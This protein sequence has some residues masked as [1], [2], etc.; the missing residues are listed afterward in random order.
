MPYFDPTQLQ[1]QLTPRG[2]PEGLSV[3]LGGG[4]LPLGTS[5][6]AADNPELAVTSMSVGYLHPPTVAAELVQA[7]GNKVG[8]GA[9]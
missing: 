9:G 1:P 2:G 6:P 7:L 5:D 4:E 3:G 8:M